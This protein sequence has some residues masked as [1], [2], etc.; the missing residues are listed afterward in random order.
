LWIGGISKRISLSSHSKGAM[1]A[2]VVVRCGLI[3][4]FVHEMSWN[5]YWHVGYRYA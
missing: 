5:M 1:V 3:I 2:Q 4:K